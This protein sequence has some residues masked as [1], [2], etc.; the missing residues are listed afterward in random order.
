MANQYTFSGKSLCA[1]HLTRTATA[2]L[3]QEVTD[4]ERWA[5][6]LEEA[7][8]HPSRP[9]VWHQLYSA[10]PA[11][12][13]PSLAPHQWLALAHRMAVQPAFFQQVWSNYWGG[14]R[15]RDT[16][17]ASCQRTT[18]CNIVTFDRSDSRACDRILELR[19]GAR[20]G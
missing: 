9:P 13:L 7:N 4:T 12:S 5:T 2:S 17:R 1:D 10:R 19:K 15:R 20:H 14:S 8:K 18:L 16:C 3:W 6:D 11:Y